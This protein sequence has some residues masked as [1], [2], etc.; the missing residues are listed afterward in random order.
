M[1]PE[2]FKEGFFKEFAFSID[3]VYAAG[4]SNLGY[5]DETDGENTIYAVLFG[6]MLELD[7]V[8]NEEVFEEPQNISEDSEDV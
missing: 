1:R 4:T 5:S 7:S 2:S 6:I 3:E 8:F